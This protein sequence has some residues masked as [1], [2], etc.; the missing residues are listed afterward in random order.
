M[1]NTNKKHEKIGGMALFNGL[2]LKSKQRETVI[3]CKKDKIKIDITNAKGN[4]SS[5]IEKI[6][7]V[8]GIYSIICMFSF[9]T[10]YIINSAKNMLEKF[11]DDGLKEE[12]KINKFE[13]VTSYIIASLIVL[14]LFIILPNLISILVNDNIKNIVQFLVQ[15]S[16]FII[17]LLLIKNIP[18]LQNVFEY[19]GAEHKV[20]NAYENLN[21]EDIT[22]E[23]VKKQSRFHKRCGGNFVIY[24]LVIFL[25]TTFMIPTTSLAMKTI[26]QIIALPFIIGMSY[27]LLFL[28]SNLQG[29]FSYISYPAMLIQFITTKEP[30]DEKIQ[31]A[32]YALFGCVKENNDIVLKEYI[33]GYIKLNLEEKEYELSDILR[34]VAKVKKVTK[35]EILVNLNSL[36]LNFEEQII[37]DTLLNKLYKDNIPLQYI[38]G[39]QYFYKEEYEVDENVLIPRADTEILVEKA[40]EY[41]NKENLETIIDMCTGSGCV[42]ISIAKNS[43]IKFGFLVDIS[44]KALEIA[45]KNNILNETNNKMSVLKSNLFDEFKNIQQNKYDIIVSNP[46]YIKTNVIKTLDKCVQNEPLLALDGGDDGLFVYKKIIKQAKNILKDNGY[47][48]LEIGYD[49]LEKITKL[50]EREKEYELIE[51]AKDLNGNDRVII[52][53]FLQK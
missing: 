50:I 29:I 7:I 28:F 35:E 31:L 14:S 18:I 38:L 49:Q 15:L 2:L 6:P 42:G 23:N 27:E 36:I 44:S 11:I 25:A 22:V 4:K 3:E 10:P 51:S 40:I 52:C 46:P 1:K 26:I 37:L 43:N 30:S 5:I 53:R 34:I 41:I 47:L 19:H 8:R 39:K 24:L 32:I 45:K 9:C 48:M 21:L 17:Y 33:N 13:I 20:V 12:V 16:M